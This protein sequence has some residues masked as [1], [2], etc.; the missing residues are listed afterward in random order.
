MGLRF[1]YLMTIVTPI[2][3]LIGVGPAAALE[4]TDCGAGLQIYQDGETE[5]AIPH[6]TACIEQDADNDGEKATALFRRAIA[7]RVLE[8]NDAFTEDFLEGIRLDREFN[9]RGSRWDIGINSSRYTRRARG[10]FKDAEKPIGIMNGSN[11][12]LRI[13]VEAVT[14]APDDP[15]HHADLGF[16]YQAARQF[17]QAIAKADGRHQTL[18]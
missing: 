17:E 18:A 15:Q 10:R 3:L 2:L 14:L 9:G 11:W 4:P 6:F 5:A 13:M 16:T 8:D 1:L 7:Y 12:R